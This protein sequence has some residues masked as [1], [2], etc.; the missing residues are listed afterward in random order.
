MKI[1][2]LDSATTEELQLC[3][4]L[5]ENSCGQAQTRTPAEGSKRNAEC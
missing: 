4:N 2:K 1:G 3:L 5:V